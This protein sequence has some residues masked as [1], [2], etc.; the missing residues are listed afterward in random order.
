M[1]WKKPSRYKVQI[2]QIYKNVNTH[3]QTNEKR[4]WVRRKR[5]ALYCWTK[6]VGPHMGAHKGKRQKQQYQKPTTRTNPTNISKI[7]EQT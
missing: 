2:Q 7:S 1:S 6:K 3:I 5:L 4:A